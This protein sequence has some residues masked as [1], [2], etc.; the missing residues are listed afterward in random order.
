MMHYGTGRRLP[1]RIFAMLGDPVV[2][3]Y[4]FRK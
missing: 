3:P 1:G 4:Q 2:T